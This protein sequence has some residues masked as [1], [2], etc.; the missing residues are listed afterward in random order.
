[1]MIRKISLTILSLI[2]VLV[3]YPVA[4]QRVQ[5]AGTKAHAY[6]QAAAKPA[7]SKGLEGEWNGTLEAGGQKLR[8]VLKIT[9]GSGDKLT[10]TIDSLDQGVND[11]PISS[12]EQKGDQVKL[13]LSG[14]GASFQGKMNA[15]SSEIS[16]DWQQGGGSLPLVFRRSSG[17]DSDDKKAPKGLPA[18]L[19][20]FEDQATFFLIV[21]EERLGVMQSTWK[22]DGHFESHT[23]ISLAGQSVQASTRIIPDADGRWTQITMEAPTGT[24]NITREGSSVKRT[25]KEKTTTWETREG[26]LLFENNAP[27][28]MSQALRQYDRSKGGVQSFPLIILPGSS[29]GFEAGGKRKQRARE[30]ELTAKE[31]RLLEYF[32]TRPG[33]ALT[34]RDI[35]NA[36]WGNSVMVTPRSV[37]RCV[38]TLRS[39][40]EADPAN[41]IF[42]QTIRD[43]G[44]R[45]ESGE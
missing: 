9:K 20:G 13:E 21:N 27:A 41:P 8:L 26:L 23:T 29:G 18:S 16:G 43:I 40:V 36:V 44:Y 28:L 14:I 37:D 24:V 12:V 10:G 30:I 35:L 19:A 34:R 2:F 11:I 25:I 33:R 45:F 17:K 39:K 15:E 31:F 1:M 42:I 6:I 3:G 4:G 5:K 38:T 32:T 7:N 22:S